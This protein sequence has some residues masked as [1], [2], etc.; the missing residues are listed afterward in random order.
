MKSKKA[1]VTICLGQEAQSMGALALPRMQAYADRVGATLIVISE[2]PQG[3]SL[4]EFYLK[5]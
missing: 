4:P 2:A 3:Y 1:I 5:I